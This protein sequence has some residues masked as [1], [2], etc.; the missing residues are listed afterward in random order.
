MR[1]QITGDQNDSLVM[2][3][4]EYGETV[5]NFQVHPMVFLIWEMQPVKFKG[6]QIIDFLLQEAK[7]DFPAAWR[8][9]CFVGVFIIIIYIFPS[10]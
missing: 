10:S 4:R 8:V 5:F 6:N 2:Q 9:V 7:Q 1:K 3:R